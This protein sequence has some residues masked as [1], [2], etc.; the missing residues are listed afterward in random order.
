[1][2]KIQLKLPTNITFV[3]KPTRPKRSTNS[4][5]ISR[6][7]YCTAAQDENGKWWAMV[8]TKGLSGY[9]DFT[10]LEFSEDSYSLKK[11]IDVFS[12]TKDEHNHYVHYIRTEPDAVTSAEHIEGLSPFCI[13]NVYSGYVMNNN[14]VKEFKM[15]KYICDLKMGKEYLDKINKDKHES[16]N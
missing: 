2:S 13:N 16:N 15:L 10:K 3:Y 7:L 14:G 4:K 6:L 5:P 12:T 9:K 1:M 11:R 8:N